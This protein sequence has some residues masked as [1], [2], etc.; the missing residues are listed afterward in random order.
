MSKID[1]HRIRRLLDVGRALMSEPDPQAVL[2]RALEAASE[3]TGARYAAL[4]ILDRDRTE[5]ARLLTTGIDGDTHRA[6]GAPPHGRGVLG[7]LITDPRPLRLTDVAAHPQSYGFPPAH[8]SMRTLLGV[9]VLVGGQP[10]GSIY[11]ADKEEGEFTEA[12]EEAVVIL[13]EWVA[14]AIANGSQRGGADP[15][16]ETERLRESMAFA[17]AER[18]RFARELHDETLQGLGGLRMLLASAA[19]RGD[20]ATTEAAL[21]EVMAGMDREIEKLRAFITDLRPAALDELGLRPALETLLDRHRSDDLRIVA[22]LE[23][24]D[25]RETD[26]RIDPDLE[27]AVYRIVQ[28]GLV[29]VIEHAQASTVRVGVASSGDGV[30]IEIEDDGSGFDPDL[31]TAGHGLAGMRERAHLQR[32]SCLVESGPGGTLLT[33]Q[34]SARR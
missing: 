15:Y 25:P 9:P 31:A 1:E 17:D 7:L 26:D 22:E 5:V 23:L 24:P 14:A 3:M 2:R 30:R 32:G 10:W 19:R 8:P 13:A 16:P 33:V 11:V 4:G 12:D 34:L 28:E 6:I 29:N 27:T 18:R 20:A 21:R